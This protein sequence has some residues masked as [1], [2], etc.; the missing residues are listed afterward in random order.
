MFLKDDNVDIEKL[1]GKGS[2]TF[3]LD[4]YFGLSLHPLIFL[5]INSSS[6]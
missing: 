2:S 1:D 5:T 6:T 4:E 3:V